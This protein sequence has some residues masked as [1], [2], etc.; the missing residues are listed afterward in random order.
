VTPRKIEIRDGKIATSLDA[1]LAGAVEGPKFAVGSTRE[2]R[3][4]T[5]AH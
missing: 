2:D 3:G 4:A 1:R 5:A